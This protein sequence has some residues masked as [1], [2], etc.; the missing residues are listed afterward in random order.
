MREPT[1][2]EIADFLEVPLEKV[3]DAII[4]SEYV[5]SNEYELN[6]EGRELTLYDSVGYEEKYYNEDILDLNKSEYYDL[7]S[8]INTF[9]N[10]ELYN[11]EIKLV[12]N[13]VR[14]KIKEDKDGN[15][16]L[17]SYRKFR[18]MI[19][20]IKQLNP[21][22][23]KNINDYNNRTIYDEDNLCEEDYKRMM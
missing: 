5:K 8:N 2:D 13:K 20:L 11:S 22:L 15:I 23:L 14:V 1:L 3:S 9:I 19:N 7:Y 10:Y 16:K 21:N 17:G 12:H 4:A 6:D 18:D